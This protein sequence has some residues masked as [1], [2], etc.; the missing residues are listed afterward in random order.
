MLFLISLLMVFVSSYMLSCVAAPKN[1]E[2]R[3]YGPAPFL[4]ILLTMFSQVVLT[5]EILSLF[6]AINEPN[7]L[8]LNV[9]FLVIAGV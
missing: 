3:L 5:F 8:V 7:V 9:I 4:Y 6:K 1:E 2:N